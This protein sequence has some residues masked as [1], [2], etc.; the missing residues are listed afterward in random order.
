MKAPMTFMLKAMVCLLIVGA[1]FAM[2]NTAMAHDGAMGVVKQRME[3]MKALGASMK[4]LAP[5][6]TGKV[7]FDAAKIAALA[8]QI[9]AK[10]GQPLVDLFPKGSLDKPSEAL[11]VIW[12]DWPKFEGL[13]NQMKVDAQALAQTA[14]TSSSQMDVRMGF[15]KVAGACKGCHMDFRQKKN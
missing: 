6:V 2:P 1:V 10:G 11:G 15:G 7:A 9:G 14:T 12:Q 13:A 3:H 5:I 8:Q 4:A